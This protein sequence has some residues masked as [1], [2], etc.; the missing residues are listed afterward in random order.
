MK[1]E[2]EG[3][4]GHWMNTLKRD[5]Y[6]P[7]GAITLEGFTTQELLSPEEAQGRSFVTMPPGTPWG[8]RWEYCWLRGRILLD[9]RAREKWIVMDLR[10][11]GEATVFLDGEAYGTRRAEWV[12]EEHHFLCDQVIHR[13]GEPLAERELL[14]EAYAGHGLPGNGSC[15]TGPLLNGEGWQAPPEEGPLTAVGESSWGIWHEEAYQLYMDVSTLL[16]LYRVVESTSLRAAKIEEALET[17]TFLVDFEQP[18]EARLKDY[19]RAREALRPALEAKN[20]STAPV[21]TAV[22]NA[23]LD[24]SWLWPYRETQRKVARTFAQQL[25]LMDLY[26]EY[27]YIQS[28]PEAYRICKQLYPRLYD[29]IRRKVRTGQWIAEGAA[30]VEPDTNMTGGEAMIRQL[31]YGKA[32]FREEFGVESRM[33]WLPDTFGYSAALPQILRGCGVEYLTTQKIF[34]NYNGA[35]PFPYHYFTWQ[36]IDGSEVVSF[37]HMDYT[38]GTDPQSVADKWKGRVQKRDLD[39]FLLPCGYGDGGGG[40]TRDHLEYLRRE[41][42]L[43]G[44]PRV[45][46]DSPVNFFQKLEKNGKPVNRYAGELYFACHRGTYTSQARMKKHNRLCETALRE[47]EIWSAAA[48]ERTAYPA[49]ILK[50]CWRLTLLNQFHDILPGSS[51]GRVYREASDR[52]RQVLTETEAAVKRACGAMTAGEGHTW[53]NSLSWER[54][55]TADTPA[56]PVWVRIPPMGWT[57]GT[58]PKLPQVPVRCEKQG[59]NWVLSN[60][61]MSVTVDLRGEIIACTDA[62]G[63]SRI[64][65]PANRLRLFRDV[66]RKFDAWDIDCMA[67]QEEV[68]LEG[69]SRIT[70][71]SGTPWKAALE[72]TRKIGRSDW[73]QII[74]L[75]ADS[76]RVEFDT[77]VDW[78]EKHRLLKAAFPTGIAA[79]EAMEEIQFGYVKRPTHRSRPYDADRFEVCNHRY[80]AL[81]DEGRGAAVLNDC[82]YGVS[83]LGDE[84]ALTL[85]RAPSAPDPDADRGEHAFRYAYTFW[86]GPW[87]EADVVRQAYEFNVP[88]TCAPGRVETGSLMEVACPHVIVETVKQAEDGSGDLI[89]RLYECKHA[90][91]ETELK[92]HFPI[93]RAWRCDM[94]ENREDELPVRDGIIPLKFRG[95]EIKTLRIAK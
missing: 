21:F 47:A 10:P 68:P 25:R 29:R 71:L 95:F 61:R 41:K 84:I 38:S 51:I 67:Y 14:M 9:E 4:I 8:R 49:E 35:D 69:E 27:R 58:D 45:E 85:L 92:L 31:V 81:A 28:Q 16:G 12:Q 5:F 24:L 87:L 80:T 22:G 72:V 86:D 15:A 30:W 23:H 39:R 44:M 32:F 19:R 50:E 2:W 77:R 56:G 75:E 6:E 62:S 26:P 91:C 33:L 18:R 3:R 93:S 66:P 76:P 13:P 43:E 65:G 89:L 63:R 79:E 52:V 59:E 48:A 57:S 37:L 55:V 60:S 90:A 7:L 42:D 54:T 78:R 74:S 64:S 1:P 70:A 20:G 53:F 88:L 40:P 34:W 11:G 83:T 46:Q 17:F 94:Q 82:K 36:G 73:T